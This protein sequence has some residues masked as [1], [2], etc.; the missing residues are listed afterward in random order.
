MAADTGQV[1]RRC[2]IASGPCVV[3]FGDLANP[4]V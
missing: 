3:A 4:V 1:G 2:C